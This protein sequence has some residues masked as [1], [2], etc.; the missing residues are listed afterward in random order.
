VDTHNFYAAMVRHLHQL[1]HALEDE[2]VIAHVDQ[3]SGGRGGSSGRGRVTMQIPDLPGDVTCRSNRAD[4]D[5]LWFWHDDQPV[6]PADGPD[7]AHIAAEKLLELR[8]KALA[9]PSPR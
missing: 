6:T 2:N 1:K 9:A 3:P 5:H 8:A 4:A 7:E